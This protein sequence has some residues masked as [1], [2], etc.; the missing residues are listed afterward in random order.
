MI[1]GFRVTCLDDTGLRVWATRQVFET[2]A[3]ALAY[4]RTVI[5]S[6][7]PLIQNYST[8]MTIAEAEA[9]HAAL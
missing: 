9:A 8:I 1:S 4:A 7:A 5:P 3:D 2:L 6:H